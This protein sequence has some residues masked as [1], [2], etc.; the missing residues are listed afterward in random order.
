MSEIEKIAMDIVRTEKQIKSLHAAKS[1][2]I[3]RLIEIYNPILE[4]A[5]RTGKTYDEIVGEGSEKY[6][7]ESQS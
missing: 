2:L 1:R 5:G 3:E 4:E 6:V 7:S